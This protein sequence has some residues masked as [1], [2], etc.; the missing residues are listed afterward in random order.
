MEKASIMDMMVGESEPINRIKELIKQIVDTDLTVVIY[1]ESGVGKELVARSLHF[2][3]HRKDFPFVK[4]NCAAL[5]SE[6]LE[7]E[8][9]GYEKGAFTGADGLKPGKFEQAN[10]GTIFLDE[11]GDMP[12]TL[13]SKLLQVLQDGEFSRIGGKKD[14]KVNTWIV[15][16]TNHDLENEVKRGLFREDLFYR[17]NII[18]ILVPPL[19]DRK[20]DIPILFEHFLSRYG[21]Q[22]N[23]DFVL[24][25]E[26]L[27]IFS[28]YHWPGNVREM[29]NY[30][31]RLLV[32]NDWEQ[33]KEE[34]LDKIHAAP[35]RRELPI[36]PPDAKAKER[37]SRDVLEKLIDLG[38]EK[39]RII[40]LPSLKEIK[41][42]ALLK[43][44]KEVIEEVLKRTNWNKKMAARHLKV[45]Y[46]ALLYKI[47]GADIKKPP[48]LDKE[49]K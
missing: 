34:I 15:S 21:E 6:L 11:I 26:V 9:F 39:E 32:L 22:F 38:E 1:G 31:K 20:E 10:N 7:R 30:I 8:L 13:Q 37:I 28:S 42:Q 3:S 5:P 24:D 48:D 47:K 44:E 45:S 17:L 18:K 19:R 29:E 4:V 41:K 33:L 36:A 40:S 43:I 14:V 35:T 25:K 46:K 23:P 12:L 16:A 27:D 49:R 2:Q